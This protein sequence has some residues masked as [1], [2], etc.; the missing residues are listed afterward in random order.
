MKQT[1]VALLLVLSLMVSLT[2]CH[3]TV[4]ED[5]DSD[6]LGKTTVDAGIDTDDD[7]DDVDDKDDKDDKDD[8][9][10]KDTDEDADKEDAD[11]DDADADEAVLSAHYVGGTIRDEKD[12][13]KKYTNYE[14]YTL[15]K[16][17]PVVKILILTD[18][19]I[20]D[21]ELLELSL[22]DLDAE[23]E[24]AY[25]RKYSIQWTR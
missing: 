2:G 24:A 6:I 25:A 3:K 9:D 12:L 18:R 19:T 8:A 13:L 5:V 23:G 11:K 22:E 21:V 14:S 10:D 7:N 4:S 20:T 1:I 17:E 16:D 15:S